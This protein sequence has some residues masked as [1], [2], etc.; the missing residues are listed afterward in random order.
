MGEIFAFL[1]KLVFSYAAS[2]HIFSKE[3]KSDPYTT[4]Y[5]KIIYTKLTIDLEIRLRNFLTVTI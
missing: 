5:D 1:C 2:K 4:D 3:I